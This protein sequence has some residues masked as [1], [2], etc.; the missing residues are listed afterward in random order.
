MEGLF[1]SPFLEFPE[2]IGTGSYGESVSF[3]LNQ[4]EKNE[5]DTYDDL[6]NEEYFNHKRELRIKR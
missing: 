2:V 3:R 5:K 4:N 6:D 1:R